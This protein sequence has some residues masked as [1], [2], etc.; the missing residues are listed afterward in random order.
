MILH[1]DCVPIKWDNENNCGIVAQNSEEFLIVLKQHRNVMLVQS[2][3]RVGIDSPLA[4]EEKQ[5][6]IE[7]RKYLR[8][9]TKNIP[10]VLGNTLTI[11]DPPPHGG[12]VRIMDPDSAPR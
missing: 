3:W 7:Y 1:L 8:D 12:P 5:E 11:L 9:L 2:D 10:S 6:W 4:E